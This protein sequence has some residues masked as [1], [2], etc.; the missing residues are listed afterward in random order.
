MFLGRK[1]QDTSIKMPWQRKQAVASNESQIEIPSSRA[2]QGHLL[3][4]S[5]A[6]FHMGNPL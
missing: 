5:G 6:A 3:L 1:R 4:F 2:S